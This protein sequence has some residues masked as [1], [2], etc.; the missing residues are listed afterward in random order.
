MQNQFTPQFFIYFMSKKLLSLA[1]G[2]A[3]L[4]ASCKKD[5]AEKDAVVAKITDLKV[6]A[7]FTWQ[8]A[9]DVNFTIN[10]MDTRFQ[11]KIHVV[12]IYLSDPATGSI[13]VAKGSATLGTPFIAN[14]SVLATIN[15]AYIVKTAPDGSAVTEKIELNAVKVAV[16][17]SSS[18]TKNTL[19]L[20][21]LTSDVL[22]AI[23]EPECGIAIS[24]S[25]IKINNSTD[26]YCFT[27]NTDLTINVEANNGGTL[28][29]NAPGKTITFGDNFNHTN[30]K[31]FI[32][33]GTTVKFNRDLNIKAGE[34][35]INNG[36][37]TAANLSSSGSLINK[38]RAT[39]SGG[40]FN[41]NSG[42]ELTNSSTM[43][44]ESQNPSI[45]GVITNTGNLTFN[46]ATF[47]S[48]SKLNNYCSLTLNNNLQV[49]TSEF[50][51]YKLVMV[52]GDT[53]VNSSGTMN[54]FDGAMHQ[55][56]NMTNM[57]GVV[58][59]RGPLV[60]LF[61]TIG[62]VGDNVVNNNG[63]FKGAL[64]YCGTRDLE[65]NQNNKK[66][67]S[68]GAVKG[69]GV[70]I[71]KDDCNTIGNGT[72]PKAVKPDTDGDG[73]IDEQDAYPND[74][75]KAFNNYS[76][77]FQNGGSTIAFED[78]WPSVGD[79][80]LNDVVLTYRHLVVTNA[81]N[82][83][84]RIEGEWKLIAT[85]GNYKNGA[86]VQFPIAKESATNFK[87]SNGLSPEDGQDSL[88][89]ILF[90]NARNEQATWNTKLDEAI[91]ASKTYTFSFDLKNGPNFQT[92]GVNAFNPFIFNGTFNTIRGYES[93]LF[94][95]KPT[96]LVDQSLFGTKDDN[97]IQ[98]AAYS[99]TSRLPWGIEIPVATFQYPLE[100][101]SILESY[102][103]FSNWASS[104]GTLDLDWYSNSGA[105][106]RNTSKLFPSVSAS[107]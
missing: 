93:H 88:V 67:F 38:G 29:I 14:I 41:L 99:T 33:A 54:L 96:K 57:D 105:G 90:K 23:A 92:L 58:Y 45:N 13:A 6:P 102:L 3:L 74:K 40:N 62:T 2:L 22:S 72:P 25:N 83:A 30:I 91:S 27:S 12:A 8:T 26:V 32:A 60:S 20:T 21:S 81:N 84:V 18:N 97:S 77:N 61:K 104:G 39:F 76:V 98:G 103:K 35:I 24:T 4:S 85:G 63:Y 82:I 73:I 80:D 11:N 70:Y 65:V 51:N 106:Y 50:N 71:V 55:T 1:I 43:I 101:T 5:N 69:C 36:I 10:V 42:A 75:G 46:S 95:K 37:L 17:L 28:K 52:K 34:T 64:Q 86:G 53:Y 19:L 16:S 7:N 68:D 56:Q 44:V 78:S 48:G 59:G 66:H 49:N 94:G 79:Y 89:V 47:N 87:S 31:L 100:Q 107:K 9:R 15:E